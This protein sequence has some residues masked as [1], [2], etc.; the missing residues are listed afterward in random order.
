[1]Q[2]YRNLA[3]DSGVVAYDT[4]ADFIRVRFIGG[5]TY[6]YTYR[7]AG[8]RNVEQMKSLAANGKGLS[9]FISRT[10]KGMYSAKDA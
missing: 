7:S 9:T 5:E 10:I 1:M 4:G 6:L 8:A 3:G 2:P